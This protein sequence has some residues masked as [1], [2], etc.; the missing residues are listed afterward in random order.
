MEIVLFALYLF[1]FSWA[2]TQTRFLRSSG[3][4]RFQLVLLFLLKVVAA[5]LY[6]WVF[7]RQ[8]GDTWRLYQE[9]LKETRILM[10][11]PIRYVTSF[12]YDP[13][14][15]GFSGLFASRSSYWNNLKD[16]SFIRI[17][18]LFNCFSFG[19][20]FINALFYSYLTFFGVVAVYKVMRHHL[21][22]RSFLLIIACFL[23]PSFLYWTSG[24]HKDGLTYLALAAII[25]IFYF[26]VQYRKPVTAYL[27]LAAMMVLLFVLRNHVLMVLLPALFCWLLAQ[28]FPRQRIKIFTAVYILAIAC[29]FMLKYI[30]PALDLPAIVLSKQEAFMNLGGESEIA[31]K[32]LQPDFAGF[33]QL[34]PQAAGISLFRPL[35]GDINKLIIVPAFTELLLAWGCIVLCLIF[36]KQKKQYQPFSLF[37][38]AFCISMLLMIGYTV[39]NIGAVV[40]YR[41][42][43]FPFI[44]APVLC[45]TDWQK[46]IKKINIK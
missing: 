25:Y 19:S 44:I 36:P 2:I 34:L 10:T 14:G 1:L 18:S 21:N 5:L 32:K 33:V 37:L 8:G 11:N 23:A 12:F 24:L 29:F 6:G 15:N 39:N 4:S 42:F 17:E 31:V 40:R 27:I 22:S 38:L 28:K 7:W 30:D 35:P 45:C 9:S 46:L 41:A 20:Y 26:R 13:Y 16:N 3:L 43:L